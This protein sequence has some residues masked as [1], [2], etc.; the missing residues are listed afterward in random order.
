MKIIFI[1]YV[2]PESCIKN[3]SG[4]SIA[5]NKM[6]NGFLAGLHSSGAAVHC[7][8][9]SPIAPFPKDK[10]IFIKRNLI[11]LDFGLQS[12]TVGFINIPCIKQLTQIIATSIELSKICNKGDAVLTFNA[13]PQVGL[14]ALIAKYFLKIKFIPLVADLPI[15]DAKSR[16][17]I[18]SLARRMF[19]SLTKYTLTCCDKL[20]VL[21]KHAAQRYAP[22]KSYIS[23]DGG[24]DKS[25]LNRFCKMDEKIK[26]IV[27]TGALTNYSGI[28]NLIDAIEYLDGYDVYLDIYGSGDIEDVINEKIRSNNR[29][30]FFGK[31]SHQ[32]ALIHQSNAWLLVNPRSIDDD[33]ASVT[34]PSK[35]FEYLL[36]GT[37][38]LS[39]KL[40]CFD[41]K[42]SEIIY[43]CD[44][45]KPITI[46]AAI[47]K[48]I[49]TDLKEIREKTE[50]AY[51][52]VSN[53]KNWDTHA[54]EVRNFINA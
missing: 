1:G 39:T 31:V 29:I 22:G 18:S 19:D 52:F 10:K 54:V 38:I 33:I 24:V 11:F 6:Q 45:N 13:F 36:S 50:A 49:K 20:I 8:T 2:V 32:E 25:E 21:N 27:Y 37:P 43:F 48:I 5:G 9:I 4:T 17:A 16:G 41:K 51:F 34:F 23:L 44:D 35:I 12:T 30:R 7:L 46:A 3:Y 15:D 42:Y 28:I 53:E 47:K 26:N 14:P 40:N